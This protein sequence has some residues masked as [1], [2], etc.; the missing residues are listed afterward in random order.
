MNGPSI[1]EEVLGRLTWDDG[2]GCWLGEIELLPGQRVSLAVAQEG[3][4]LPVAL[5]SA[6]GTLEQIRQSEPDLR[7]RAA[8]EHL[9]RYNREWSDGLWITVEDFSERLT[10]EAILFF[11]NG[12]AELDYDDGDLF[13][14]HRLIITMNADGAFAGAILTE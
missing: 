7:Q 10:L 3:T 2:C 1:Q 11:P 14:G 8:E 6:R 5:R 4:E 9:D 13:E 12:T